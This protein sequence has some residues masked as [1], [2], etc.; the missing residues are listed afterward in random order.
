M[1]AIFHIMRITNMMPMISNI[2]Y[3]FCMPQTY[4]KILYGCTRKSDFFQKKS[5]LF[6]C[7]KTLE[8]HQHFVAIVFGHDVAEGFDVLFNGVVYPVGHRALYVGVLGAFGGGRFAVARLCFVSYN[9]L[10]VKNEKHEIYSKPINEQFEKIHESRGHSIKKHILKDEN[11]MDY[12]RVFDAAK[13][14]AYSDDVTMLPEIHKS[15]KEIR[16]RLGLVG[17]KNPDLKTKSHGLVDVKSP[18]NHKKIISN[19]IDAS[20]QGAIACLT[21][22]HIVISESEMT[23]LSK[24][25][26]NNKNYSKKEVH[27]VVNGKLYK[28]NSHGIIRD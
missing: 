24:S 4:K 21:D 17:D 16:K 28:Y 20:G 3:D 25:I 9:F 6:Y 8:T 12:D 7:A 26:L 19:A 5:L 22:D 23:S 15:E 18:F 27:W 11:S 13:L 14:Y 1:Q 10:Y 2:F